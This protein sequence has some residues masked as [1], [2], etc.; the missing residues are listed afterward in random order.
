MVSISIYKEKYFIKKNL[1]QNFFEHFS[2]VIVFE[3][4]ILQ[5]QKLLDQNY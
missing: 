4:I 3:E 2:K 1:D 5:Q